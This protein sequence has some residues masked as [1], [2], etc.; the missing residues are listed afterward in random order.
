M[1]AAYPE[2]NICLSFTGEGGASAA[3][4]ANEVDRDIVI[5]GMDDSELTLTAIKNGTQYASMA[6]NCYKWGYYSTKMAFLAAVDRLDEMESTIIDSGVVMIT[7]EN[8]DTYA[9]ELFIMP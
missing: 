2:I 3:Q 7:A 5:I 6:Q 1:F 8:T 4:S 9:D